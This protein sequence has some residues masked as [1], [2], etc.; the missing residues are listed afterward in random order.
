MSNLKFSIYISVALLPT[1]CFSDSDLGK[2]KNLFYAQVPP[3]FNNPKIGANIF[4]FCYSGFA[5]SYSGISKTGIWSAEFITPQ[6]LKLAQQISRED[7]FQEETRIPERYRAKL[8]DYRGS[9]MD[10]GHLS[11]SAQ[12][13]SRQAQSDS[14]YLTNI[15]P[16]ASSNNQGL[17][18]DIE[19]ATR[20]YIK[21]T[22]QP[23][24][25]ITGTL[26]I[27][28]KL[29]TIGSG[30]LVPTHVYK[31]IYFP[32]TNIAGAYVAINDNSG[33]VDTVSI[34][35]LEQYSGVNFFPTK[36]GDASLTIRY[37]LPLTPNHTS[38]L[39]VISRK[40]V[41]Q[42]QIFEM[43]PDNSVQ[44]KATRKPQYQENRGVATDLG[45]GVANDLKDASISIIRKIL[46]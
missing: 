4:Q 41:N 39:R 25:M 16:Q 36:R 34:R 5:V 35:Q 12:R 43:L 28:P 46:N 17:W 9:G 6:K 31:V 18:A 29:K 8:K 1:I 44:S 21:K 33:R 3:Q 40:P 13:E 14:F 15:F 22:N 38:K 23:A 19:K 32:S 24:Y 10:R 42:S 20:G 27:G 2:C 26:F 45:K 11:P 30:V 7:N 37:D